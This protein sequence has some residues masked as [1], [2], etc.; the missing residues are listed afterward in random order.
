MLF[1]PNKIAESWECENQTRTMT[2]AFPRRNAF[3]LVMKMVLHLL[4]GSETE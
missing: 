2:T 1:L 3:V 4:E